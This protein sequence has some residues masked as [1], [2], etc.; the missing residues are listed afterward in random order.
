MFFSNKEVMKNSG[1]YYFFSSKL[2]NLL[3]FRKSK[4]KRKFS[5]LIPVKT[6]IKEHF[7]RSGA[8]VNMNYSPLSPHSL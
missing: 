5:N 4:H 7:E 3:C 2:V 1:S 8:T 6:I